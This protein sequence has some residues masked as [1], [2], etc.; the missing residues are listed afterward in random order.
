M[1][2]GSYPVRLVLRDVNGEV[3]REIEELCDRLDSAHSQGAS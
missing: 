1:K 2:D 3:Y